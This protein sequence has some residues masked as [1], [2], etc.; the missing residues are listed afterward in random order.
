MKM[1]IKN[2]LVWVAD[3]P[4]DWAAKA[5]KSGLMRGERKTGMLYGVASVR[6]LD[7]IR[8]AAGRLPQPA[9]ELRQSLIRRQQAVEAERA[10]PEPV[11]LTEYPVSRK[12]FAHQVRGA[13]M[14]LLT[15]GI[16]S[17]DKET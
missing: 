16:I 1:A 10:K 7:L 15:M 6:T 4:A 8:E 2:G 5:K 3:A 17:P 12:L 14:A 11:P 9:E 13:N